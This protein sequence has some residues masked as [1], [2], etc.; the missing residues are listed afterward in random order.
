MS[1]REFDDIVKRALENFQPEYDPLSW[2]QLNSRISSA[3]E[4][5]DDS[6]RDALSSFSAGAPADW[7]VME[8]MIESS[9]NV[10]FDEE[11][12]N[13]IKTYQEP[14]DPATWPRLD[15][16]IDEYE[17]LRRRLILSKVMEVAAVL[18]LIL[19][20]VNLWPEIKSY[21]L[22]D[23]AA[24]TESAEKSAPVVTTIVE[25]QEINSPDQQGDERIAAEVRGIDA[26]EITAGAAKAMSAGRSELS[27]GFT[28]SS[29]SHAARSETA[30]DRLTTQDL[31]ELPGVVSHQLS[32]KTSDVS[33][34]IVAGVPIAENHVRSVSGTDMLAGIEPGIR[35]NQG[36]LITAVVDP[37]THRKGLRMSFGA[38]YDINSLYIPSDQFYADGNPIYFEEKHLLASGYSAGATILFDGKLLTL[39]TG[40]HYSVK[41]YEPNRIIKIGQTFDVS[42]IDFQ[43]ISLQTVHIPANVQWYFDKR[44]KT[45][46]YA[47]AGA[48]LN[49]VVTAHYDLYVES[50]LRSSPGGTRP[51]PADRD[52]QQVREHFLDGADFS[53]KSFVTVTGALGVD[54]SINRKFSVFMQPTYN[55]QVPFFELTDL[56]GKRLRY[57]SLQFGTRVNLR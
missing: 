7:D 31:S 25:N 23:N 50:E 18:L 36:Q 4:D 27:S 39:E 45:R 22:K 35:S 48:G 46:F 29:G 53:S 15:R 52:I 33:P 11:V 16:K 55:H 21:W 17:R 24:F 56:G 57:L 1:D 41:K 14:Y 13:E 8:Q 30:I 34:A 40:L 3:D 19:T 49:F 2:N 12:K 10:R 47:L 20:F 43:Q 54:H 32:A 26:S 37:I 5:F 6:M 42:T 28:G 44:G 51:D 9:E 38:S